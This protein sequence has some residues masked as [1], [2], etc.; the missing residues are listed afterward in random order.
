MLSGLAPERGSSDNCCP[1][2]TIRKCSLH[3]NGASTAVGGEARRCTAHLGISY[4]QVRWEP[5]A[6]PVQRRRPAAQVWPEQGRQTAP[7]AARRTACGHIVATDR[8]SH[9]DGDASSSSIRHQAPHFGGE[10]ARRALGLARW[11][12]AFDVRG[13]CCETEAVPPAPFD[14]PGGQSISLR[15]LDELIHLRRHA[16]TRCRLLAAATNG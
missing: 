5:V 2:S 15:V 9:A 3:E 11:R 7:Q 12:R 16:T 14:S 4:R 6:G 13:T 8:L 1:S 10:S